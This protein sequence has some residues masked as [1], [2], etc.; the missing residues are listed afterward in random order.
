M[1]SADGAPGEGARD[2]RARA[3]WKQA[4]DTLGDLLPDTTTDES[5]GGWGERDDSSRDEDLLRDV[6]PHH[7]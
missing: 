4:A 3:H 6:P 1:S 2:V 5:D 7:G